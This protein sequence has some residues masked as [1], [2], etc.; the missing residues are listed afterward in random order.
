MQYWFKWH[1]RLGFSLCLELRCC[2]QRQ[3]V[4]GPGGQEGASAY[5]DDPVANEKWEALDITLC[6]HQLGSPRPPHPQCPDIFPKKQLLPQK[7]LQEDGQVLPCCAPHRSRPTLGHSMVLCAGLGEKLSSQLVSRPGP[8]VSGFPALHN[9]SIRAKY[10]C[11][12]PLSRD[13]EMSRAFQKSGEKKYYVTPSVG[14]EPSRH[15]GTGAELE[16]TPPPLCVSFSRHGSK[17]ELQLQTPEQRRETRLESD[18]NWGVRPSGCAKLYLH[19]LTTALWDRG[20][21]PVKPPLLK[22][23]LCPSLQTL[24]PRDTFGPFRI[25]LLPTRIHDRLRQTQGIPKPLVSS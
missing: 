18:R 7:H 6:H 13:W 5:G 25:K 8:L 23:Q 10:I 1:F 2:T 4:L 11:H 16:T 17:R 20:G 22:D 15:G 14:L 19:F 21:H 3:Q 12:F 24:A 9:L